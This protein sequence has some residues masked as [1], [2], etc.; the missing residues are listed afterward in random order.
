MKKGTIILIVSI[1]TLLGVIALIVWYKKKKATKDA[2]NLAANTFDVQA[3]LNG[4]WT[5]QYS[6]Q[7]ATGTEQPTIAGSTYSLAGSPVY[8]IS[9]P[10]YDD[11]KKT[12]TFHKTRISNSDVLPDE[13]LVID[14]VK[15]TMTGMAGNYSVVYTK[16]S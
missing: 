14:S 15:K 11:T 4:N 13:I 9:T 12:I 1:L 10:V 7:G 2:S 5:M 8:N 3:F 6:Y 16:L